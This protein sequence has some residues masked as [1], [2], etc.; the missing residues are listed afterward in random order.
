MKADQ[1]QRPA[2]PDLAPDDGAHGSRPLFA[3]EAAFSPRD[4]FRLGAWG[5]GAIGALIFAF[6][7]SGQPVGAMRNDDARA[8][9]AVAATAPAIEDLRRDNRRLA[10]ALDV[11]NNDRDRLYARLT[12]VEKETSDA[13]ASL[14]NIADTL[15]TPAPTADLTLATA[16]HFTQI[17]MGAS[18]HGFVFGLPAPA[19]TVKLSETPAATAGSQSVANTVVS[20]EDPSTTGS[21]P[22]ASAAAE[23]GPSAE[24]ADAAK[25]AAKSDNAATM[26]NGSAAIGIALART[27]SI[28]KLQKN[29]NVLSRKYKAILEDKS[30]RIAIAG[31]SDDGSVELSL[32]AGPFADEAAAGKACTVLIKDKRPCAPAPFTGQDL[33]AVIAAAHPAAVAAD[34]KKQATSA[35]SSNNRKPRNRTADAEPRAAGPSSSPAPFRVFF[36][37]R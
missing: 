24:T 36:N 11:L 10:A 34:D 6:W 2:P 31:N 8:S 12:I 4:L 16:Q 13:K 19:N 15:T 7:L 29:W 21:V 9:Q 17:V 26:S 23:P 33:A 28:S 25:S 22:T 5:A 37:N 14:G 18:P 32:V 30:V 3:P 20:T 35:P 1:H 27:P